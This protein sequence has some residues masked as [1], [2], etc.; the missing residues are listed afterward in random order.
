MF[1]PIVSVVIAALLMTGAM[2][3]QPVSEFGADTTKN[4]KNEISVR[5]VAPE[6]TGVQQT[7]DQVPLVTRQQAID[8]A[9]AHAGLTEGEATSLRAEYDVERTGNHW[10]VDFRAGDWEYDYE[11]DAVT[12]AVTK[13]EKEYDPEKKPTEPKPTEQKTAEPKATEPKPTEAP[14][15]EKLTR[16][17]AIDAALTHAGLT[18]GEVTRLEAEYDFD[19]GVYVW[20]VEFRNGR[21]EYSYELCAS[22]GKILSWEKEYDD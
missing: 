18:E 16:Q 15:A 9:L 7:K 6:D 12:G 22:D 10:D 3:G 20:E 17:Q 4:V 8:A 21:Y 14:A 13:H 5:A 1:R 11:V 19:D 2:L